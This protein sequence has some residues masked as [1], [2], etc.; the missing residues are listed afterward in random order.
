MGLQLQVQV[1]RCFSN[2]QGRALASCFLASQAGEVVEPNARMACCINNG[3]ATWYQSLESSMS[4]RPYSEMYHPLTPSS[5]MWG[6]SL[7]LFAHFPLFAQHLLYS[8][9]SH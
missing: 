4:R 5:P 1:K 3:D 2:L 7:E 6:T 8:L 9:N